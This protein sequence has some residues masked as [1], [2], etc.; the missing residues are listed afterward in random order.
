MK[1]RRHPGGQGHGAHESEGP[2]TAVEGP[3]RVV[4]GRWSVNPLGFYTTVAC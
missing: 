1:L 2:A 4:V 3:E